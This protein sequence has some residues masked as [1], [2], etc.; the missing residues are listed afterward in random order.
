MWNPNINFTLHQN[1]IAIG[2]VV[3]DARPDALNTVGEIL[4][5]LVTDKLPTAEEL[6]FL[7]MI[8]FIDGGLKEM[9]ADWEVVRADKKTLLDAAKRSNIVDLVTFATQKWLEKPI[10]F[11]GTTF[12]DT[13]PMQLYAQDKMR[14][15][16]LYRKIKEC[17]VAVLTPQQDEYFS[18]RY[19]E[20]MQKSSLSE[21]QYIEADNIFREYVQKADGTGLTPELL[22]EMREKMQNEGISADV[23]NSKTAMFDSIA[24]IAEAAS[25]SA[26]DKFKE[27]SNEVSGEKPG[28]IYKQPFLKVKLSEEL[29][30]YTRAK[31]DFIRDK[32]QY[33]E[34]LA[35]YNELNKLY[36]ASPEVPLVEL[37]KIYDTNAISEFYVPDY[38]VP[39]PNDDTRLITIW[40]TEYV[41]T[42]IMEEEKK[43]AEESR[44]RKAKEEEAKAL[45]TEERSKIRVKHHFRIMLLELC[46]VD[47]FVKVDDSDIQS[48]K[49]N[50]GIAAVVSDNIAERLQKIQ[51]VFPKYSLQKYIEAFYMCASADAMLKTVSELRAMLS[52]IEAEDIQVINVAARGD[53]LIDTVWEVDGNNSMVSEAPWDISYDMFTQFIIRL[54]AEIEARENRKKELI[55]QMQQMSNPDIQTEREKEN[56][57][58][59]GI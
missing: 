41:V 49:D 52:H 36:Y 4:E 1:E 14:C 55:K 50:K 7:K 3:V 12:G 53:S 35:A 58:N 31:I 16:E 44:L 23:V 27:E 48:L 8:V 40:D 32:V 33:D 46:S 43:T 47:K 34:E 22:Q 42:K 37:I 45:D 59:G 54:K 2:K 6:T 10:N 18:K 19:N 51:E 24:K 57:N 20:V 28:H 21:V 9:Q 26:V 17:G 15:A 5:K 25:T 39:D 38:V 56:V 29:L 11:V 30:K 13:T